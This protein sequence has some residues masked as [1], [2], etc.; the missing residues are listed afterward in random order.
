MI[1]SLDIYFEQLV[2]SLFL[3]I[4]ETFSIAPKLFYQLYIIYGQVKTQNSQIVLLV[5]VLLTKKTIAIYIEIFKQLV[6][7][8]KSKD[9][10]LFLK[11]IITDFKRAI[12]NASKFIFPNVKNKVCFFHLS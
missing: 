6:K 4:D 3:I 8:A 11:I 5:Y 7:Y 9:L 10:V 12:I 1:F 2:N